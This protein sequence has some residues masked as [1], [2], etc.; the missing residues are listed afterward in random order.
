MNRIERALF[1]I[2]WLPVAASLPG[3]DL[4][5]LTA[6]GFTMTTVDGHSFNMTEAAKTHS[7][8][9]VIFIST[10]CP[11][12]NYYN[13][14][15]ATWRRSSGRR[16]SSSSASTRGRSRRSTRSEG[17]CPRARPHLRHHQGPGR[18]IADF[19]MRDGLRGVS[20]RPDRDVA[21]PRP[22]RL[23]AL[24]A[25]SE[26]RDRSDARGPRHPPRRDQGLRLRDCAH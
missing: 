9:A 21:L 10:I 2:L 20:L 17:A 5:R 12:S 22:C 14:L 19:W 24:L 18:Q 15:I 4:R 8:V 11:Y 6:P 16:A 25:G 3:L 1:L 23:E 7:G 26:V 13:D